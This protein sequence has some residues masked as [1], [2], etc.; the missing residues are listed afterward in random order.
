[1]CHKGYAFA[2][3]INP[4]LYPE[5]RRTKSPY[6]S[7]WFQIEGSP[8]WPELEFTVYK[9]KTRAHYKICRRRGCREQ[10]LSCLRHNLY[11][12]QDEVC[13]YSDNKLAYRQRLQFFRPDGLFSMQF[14]EQRDIGARISRL[15]SDGALIPSSGQE[16]YQIGI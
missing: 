8:S 2:I 14:R 9:D 12:L 6:S 16:A 11:S 5:Q 15:C 13:Q 10:F 1:M 4:M 7:F 3:V